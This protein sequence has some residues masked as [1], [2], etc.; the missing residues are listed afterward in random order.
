MAKKTES[1]QCETNDRDRPYQSI[2]DRIR[3]FREQT[4][5]EA[6]IE[7]ELMYEERRE[8]DRAIFGL[9][10]WGSEVESDTE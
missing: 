4:P 2:E 7:D 9:C 8:A 5:E 3:A 10:T 6:R 1:E